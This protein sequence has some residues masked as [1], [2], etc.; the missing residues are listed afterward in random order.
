MRRTNMPSRNTQGGFSLLEIMIGAGIGLMGVLVIMQAFQV[1]ES[2]RRSTTGAG[3]SQANGAIALFTLEREIK[4]AGYGFATPAALDCGNVHWHYSG[5]YSSPPDAAGTLPSIRVAPVVIAAGASGAPDSVTV[6]YGGSADR[7]IPATTSVGPDA[8]TIFVS[9]NYG[10]RAN[11]VMLVVGNGN[12][13]LYAATSTVDPVSGSTTADKIIVATSNPFNPVWGAGVMPAVI[14]GK[15]VFGLGQLTVNRFAI[16]GTSLEMTP[17]FNN[18]PGGAS[19]YSNVAQLLSTNIVDLKAWYGKDT[20]GDNKLDLWDKVTPT[21]SAGWLQVKAI[22][23]AVLSR[24]DNYEVPADKSAGCT[25]TLN[26][27]ALSIQYFDPQTNTT[28]PFSN[29]PGGFPNCYRFRAFDTVI[30]I[31][32]MLWRYQ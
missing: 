6:M 7:M 12:C 28:V 5:A 4:G 15:D 21:T 20:D 2:Y 10:F 30:P 8:N 9:E 17:M 25:A 24:S 23:I 16:N 19:T 11:D 31:R 3:Q 1:N 32:N 22:R 14:N 13:Q 18:P 27:A 26:S 29:I